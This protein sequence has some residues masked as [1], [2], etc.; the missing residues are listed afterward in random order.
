MRFSRSIASVSTPSMREPRGDHQSRLRGAHDQHGGIAIVIGDGLAA[1]VGPVL[2]AEIA[3]P[4]HVLPALAVGRILVSADLVERGHQRP[5]AR[6]AAFGDQA[7]DAVAGTD[8]R[9]RR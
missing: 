7:H 9:S 2:A 1:A 3:L 4:V 8:R 5:G 6:L